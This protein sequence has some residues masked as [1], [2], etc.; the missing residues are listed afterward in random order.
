MLG[1]VR[2]AS[3]LLPFLATSADLAFFIS[4]PSTRPSL[5][6]CDPLAAL[7]S[8]STSSSSACASF[9]PLVLHSTASPRPSYLPYFPRLTFPFPG[10]SPASPMP[11]SSPL[12][13]YDSI[14]HACLALR[15]YP[16]LIVSPSPPFSGLLP[17]FPPL[18]SPPSSVYLAISTS[19][20]SRPP[21][22]LHSIAPSS[23]PP[24]SSSPPSPAHISPTNRPFATKP[25]PFGSPLS[26]LSP[27]AVS[28]F[29]QGRRLRR[30]RLARRLVLEALSR[31]TS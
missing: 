1:L 14:L 5:T 2:C 23:P 19:R 6:S 10:F 30:P 27:C 22:P 3:P 20:I 4:S 18:L 24:P 13:S 9:D 21:S 29:R 17:S 25:P 15:P 28:S 7:D 11:S 16:R 8:L 12:D 26:A 31:S